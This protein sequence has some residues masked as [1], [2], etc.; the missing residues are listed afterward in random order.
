MR[1]FY[2]LVIVLVIL[3]CGNDDDNCSDTAFLPPPQGIYIKLVNSAGDPL[4]G[5][6]FVKDSFKLSNPAETVYVKP[7]RF[8]AQDELFIGY[9]AVTSGETYFLELDETDTDTLRMEHSLK[10]SRCFDF[11][12]LDTFTYNGQ[13]L[14][15]DEPLVTSF[16]TIVKD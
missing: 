3:S 9:D 5:T 11:R 7:D 12:S 2:A 8:G 15:D 16:N 4:I 10:E 1:K 14:Y 13:L 6:I